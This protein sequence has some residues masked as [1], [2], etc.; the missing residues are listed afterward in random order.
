[1]A[2]WIVP[3]DN[4]DVQYAAQLE[5][6]NDNVIQVSGLPLLEHGF[7]LYYDGTMVGDYSKYTTNY[8]APNLPFGTYQYSN[9][10][11]KWSDVHRP[12]VDNTPSEEDK[13]QMVIDRNITQIQPKLQ[14]IQDSI[15]ALYMMLS[16]TDISEDTSTEE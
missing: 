3:C 9:N 1:M 11:L 16:G 8:E 15:F 2:S 6:I 7:Y 12:I 5:F 13:I 4:P 10:G 14:S